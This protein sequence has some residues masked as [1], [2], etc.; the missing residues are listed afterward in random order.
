[1]LDTLSFLSN[2]ELLT[3]GQ[4]LPEIIHKAIVL[5]EDPAYWCGL[6]K[7][8]IREHLKM[9]DG[10]EYSRCTPCR[11]NHPDATSV[12]VEGA[13][14]RACN[15]EGII[16]PKLLQLLDQSVLNYLND[17]G[18]TYVGTE[19]GIWNPHDVGWF[20]YQYGHDHA[21]NLLHEVYGKVS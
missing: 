6:H 10:R 20:C 21:M 14:A 19:S 18:V 1:M 8:C 3:S 12:N 5:I 4:T 9:D 17:R 2:C 11:I 16:P 7:A 15:N 13:V